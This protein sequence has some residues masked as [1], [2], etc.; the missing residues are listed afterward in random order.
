[1]SLVER[2]TR[3]NVYFEPSGAP[4]IVANSKG[5]KRKVSS[6]SL[7]SV[8]KHPDPLLVDFISRCL[9]WDPEKRITPTAALRHEFISGR[10]AAPPPSTTS[11]M[12]PI[13]PVP[14][15]RF[16]EEIN[17]MN[18]MHQ[19]VFN[20]NHFRQSFLEMQKLIQQQQQ[21]QF[22]VNVAPQRHFIPNGP[23]GGM[24]GG[25]ASTPV[26]PP[27]Q[28]AYGNVP[29]YDPYVSSY[30]QQRQASSAYSTTPRIQG[31]QPGKE[32]KYKTSQLQQG[33]GVTYVNPQ[34][35]R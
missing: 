26:L 18:S 24:S 10:S 22:P 31:G 11:N 1:M 29:T 16:Q 5:K 32:P 2:G 7:S 8:L 35:W 6:K 15:R 30:S 13:A 25:Y 9:E 23:V 21:Q 34:Q 3:R 12:R 27:I 20:F 28:G 19:Y 14:D 17:N 4:K 33:R